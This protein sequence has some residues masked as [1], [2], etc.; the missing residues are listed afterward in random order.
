[1]Q[2]IHRV[3]ISA[4]PQIRKELA[5]LGVAV[6][7]GFVT[8]EVD[9]SSPEWTAIASWIA[10]RSAVDVVSTKFATSEL[11]AAAWFAWAPTWH[12]GYPQPEDE[13]LEVTYDVSAYCAACGVGAVQRA[14]FRMKGEPRWGR[15]E[16][17]QL[18]W[19]FGE[20]FATPALWRRAF[21]PAGVRSRAVLDAGGAKE[22]SSVV[23][24]VVSDEVDVE[25]AGLTFDT[26]SRCHRQKFHP[27]ARGFFPA[28][29]AEPGERIVRTR[30][31][32]GSGASAYQVVLAA[33]SWVRAL[34][35]VRGVTF[36]P[37]A[38]RS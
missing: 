16:I 25:T 37:A 5:D 18:N 26:C 15:N 35:G 32:F 1:M 31:W 7:E 14:P 34:K 13:Y 24:L 21:E 20:Y 36:V 11:N 6:G 19:V 30:Q 29:L 12:C 3:S 9:E 38:T 17:L 27:Q 33:R 28:V 10:R 23:Q 2:V 4:T 22:L 8:F